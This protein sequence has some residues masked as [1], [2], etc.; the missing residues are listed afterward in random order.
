VLLSTAIARMSARA[1][2][3]IT[4]DPKRAPPQQETLKRRLER[5]TA[6]EAPARVGRSMAGAT[7]Q[8]I[9]AMLP[10][11]V[12]E[13][14]SGLRSTEPGH[15]V[16][17]TSVSFCAYHRSPTIPTAQPEILIA[18]HRN[19]T[20]QSHDANSLTTRAK[21]PRRSVLTTNSLP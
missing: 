3:V 18:F 12:D 2:A 10:W 8:P 15:R 1:I 6:K 19:R 5:L 17:L 4:L 14:K 7:S 20:M 21:R 9:L 13:N 11:S 16:Q